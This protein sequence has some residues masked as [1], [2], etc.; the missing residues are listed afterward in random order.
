VNGDRLNFKAEAGWVSG[1]L[2]LYHRH[3][4]SVD[5]VKRGGDSDYRLSDVASDW[6]GG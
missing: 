4:C 1:G 6:F 3:I 2:V 5:V